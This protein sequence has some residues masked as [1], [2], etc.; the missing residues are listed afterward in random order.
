[1]AL[2]IHGTPRLW[3]GVKPDQT[4][5]F[6]PCI[7]SLS[8]YPNNTRKYPNEKRLNTGIFKAKQL[9]ILCKNDK[10]S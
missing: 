3:L 10:L 6:A 2:C 9:I 5:D 8:K 7:F 4:P 1:M